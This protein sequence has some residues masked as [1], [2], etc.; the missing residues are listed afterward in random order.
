MRGYT[1]PPP[2]S[3][4]ILL[5]SLLLTSST[6]AAQAIGTPKEIPLSH[7]SSLR[8]EN[9]EGD[10]PSQRSKAPEGSKE[11]EEVHEQLPSLVQKSAWSSFRRTRDDDRD[12]KATTR[13]MA[14]HKTKG[15]SKRRVSRPNFVEQE[16]VE[17]QDMVLG[18]P[19]LLFVILLDILGLLLYV[20]TIWTVTN[21]S[22]KKNEDEK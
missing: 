15:S 20:F 7:H 22:K 12:A 18:V 1:A 14:R 11:L 16:D 5:I 2:L 10:A 3:P 19:K 17:D 9:Y 13:T 6:L 4:L 21:L 8:L